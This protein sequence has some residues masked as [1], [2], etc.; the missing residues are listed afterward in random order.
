MN[1][2]ILLYW[3][4]SAL[5]PLVAASAAGAAV[6]VGLAWSSAPAW[7]LWTA[8]AGLVVVDVAIVVLGCVLGL[9]VPGALRPAYAV[10]WPPAPASGSAEGDGR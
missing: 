10:G 8:L 2:P 1:L 6:V 9:R 4:P 5:A 3:R 7:A